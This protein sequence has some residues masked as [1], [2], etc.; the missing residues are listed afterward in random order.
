[1]ALTQA[2]HLGTP[3]LQER[4]THNYWDHCD[5]TPNGQ[6]EAEGSWNKL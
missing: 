4:N 6:L 3:K 5:D 2:H 1:M